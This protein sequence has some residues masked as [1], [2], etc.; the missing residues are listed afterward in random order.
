MT[1]ELASRCAADGEFRL[2]ARHWT[3]GFRFEM[4]DD[5]AQV[6]MVD[7]VP[8]EGDPG[9]ASG[10]IILTGPTQL[11]ADLRSTSPPRFAT[12]VLAAL[13]I[14]L[15]RHGDPLAFWQYYPALQRAVELLRPAH[16]SAE[17]TE[18]HGRFDSPVG[19]YIHIEIGGQDHRV[20][21]EE[22]GQ[23]IPL[24]LQHTAGS[25][26]VQWRHLFECGE[27]T[28]H[29]RLIAYDLPFHG[30]SLPPVGPRWWEAPYLLTAERARALPLALLDTLELDRPVFM[31]CSV[32]GLLA[33][34][35]AAHHPGRFRA[36]IAVEGAL[37]IDGNVKALTG[38]WHPQV[39]NDTKARMMEGL[40]A[41]TAP[42]SY[43][44]ET[45]YAYASGWPQSFTGD[46]NYYFDD[47]DVRTP[48]IDTSQTAVHILT[49]EYDHSAP[50]EAGQAA[51]RAI[52][53]STFEAMPGL[54]HFPMCEDPQRFLT[55]L[56]P[57]L[58]AVRADP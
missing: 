41:P 56:L 9:N 42:I 4:G 45:S 17:T 47:F 10:V 34:D 5:Q 2:A 3:G 52:E 35:L 44:K 26:G 39:S 50:V 18:E 30:K 7:G 21:F 11:W 15:R 36:V 40:M 20:Y 49:G 19:R 37:K 6:R 16:S 27:I 31:G 38:F 55:H 14:G 8:Q 58:R 25:H 46:L 43:R 28:D 54:G 29:F 32:G 53:G 23:G 13:G 12:D 1:I 57:L 24:L 48:R 51:H 33:L 22:A